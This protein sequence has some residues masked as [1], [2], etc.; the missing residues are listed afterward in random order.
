MAFLPD[1]AFLA[2]KEWMANVVRKPYTMKVKD[3]DNRLKML[4][5]F[6]TLM[7]HDDEKDAVFTDANLKALLLK[8]MPL[9]WQNSYL[10]KGTCTSDNFRRML[11]YFVQLQ[12]ITD[13]QVLSRSGATFQ[14]IDSRNQ[15]KCIRTNRGQNGHFP[16]SFQ[17]R[18][19]NMD[20][21]P[22]KQ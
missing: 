21:I 11:S 10:Q 14:N 12:S 3:L 8:S 22:R 16:S 4:N 17:N 7:P 18:Q 5:R 9:T 13:T 1:D 15:H 20:H 2:Q 19:N 6:L